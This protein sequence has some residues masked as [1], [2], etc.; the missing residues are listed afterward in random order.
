[1]QSKSLRYFAKLYVCFCLCVILVGAIVLYGASGLMS[2]VDSYSSLYGDPPEVPAVTI[3]QL[4]DERYNLEFRPVW[5]VALAVFHGIDDYR[6][7]HPSN[8]LMIDEGIAYFAVTGWYG[9]CDED[10]RWR[11]E[12]FPFCL[13]ANTFLEPVH[14]MTHLLSGQTG[15]S[16]TGAFWVATLGNWREQ[17]YA[18]SQ[19][20]T[21]DNINAQGEIISSVSVLTQTVHDIL[22]E[23]VARRGFSISNF[24]FGYRDFSVGAFAFAVLEDGILINYYAWTGDGCENILGWLTFDG[25]LIRIEPPYDFGGY[26]SDI[27]RFQRDAVA[28]HF[29][30]LHDDGGVIVRPRTGV[31]SDHRRFLITPLINS[32]S[33]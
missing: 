15:T 7:M 13:E 6:H 20:L 9:K 27:M 19:T 29:S 4:S 33:G 22:G 17:G 16:R 28:F 12:V 18:M 10:L 24:T 26:P 30:D 11:A 31:I 25:E 5:D 8:L 32:D 21:F 23:G 14:H 1:M 2:L 3:E